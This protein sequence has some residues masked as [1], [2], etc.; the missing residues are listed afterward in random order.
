MLACRTRPASGQRAQAI[1]A[2][3]AVDPPLQL[4]PGPLLEVVNLDLDIDFH[5]FAKT[6]PDGGQAPVTFE[7]DE[8]A[9]SQVDDLDVRD[10]G[11]EFLEKRDWQLTYVEDFRA[12]RFHDCGPSTQGRDRFV[13]IQRMNRL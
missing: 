12:V 5:P 7:R 11:K 10:R 8:T 2:A 13:T 1:P 9:V 4:S 3:D 6:F